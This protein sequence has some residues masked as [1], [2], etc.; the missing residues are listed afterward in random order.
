MKNAPSLI[1]AAMLAAAT[2]ALAADY[3]ITSLAELQAFIESTRNNDYFGDTIR[4]TA[5]IDC[6]GGRFNTGDPEYPSTFAG[7][8]DGQGHTIS[9]FVHASTGGGDYGYGVAMFDFAETGATIKNLTLEGSL[10][11]TASA[12][13]S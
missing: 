1:P 4:L 11:G 10:P 5:D 12:T 3:T 13:G 9:N 2:T 8:F 6:E 7:T